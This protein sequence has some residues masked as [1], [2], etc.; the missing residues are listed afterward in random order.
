M[1]SYTRKY[2]D[3]IFFSPN[4]Y[5][6][7]AAEFYNSGPPLLICHHCTTC[8]PLPPYTFSFQSY[9]AFCVLLLYFFRST[10]DCRQAT[11]FWASCYWKFYCNYY[12]L[13]I[14]LFIIKS[15]SKYR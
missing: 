3:K 2:A 13:F 1:Y 14:Y 5:Y 4:I 12:Y 11:A 10:S 9:S 6:W 15:Y 7:S 8:P